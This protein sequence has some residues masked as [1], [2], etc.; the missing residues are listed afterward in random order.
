MSA[1]GALEMND[2]PRS[3]LGWLS[4]TRSPWIV[5]LPGFILLALLSLPPFIYAV[6]LSFVNIDVS[7]PNNPVKFVWFQNYIAVLGSANG[8]HALLIT[9][10]V[11]FGSTLAAIVVGLLIA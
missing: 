8:S 7:L 2:R 4:W 5:P 3:A 10:I 1:T 9:L 11:S 6:Y